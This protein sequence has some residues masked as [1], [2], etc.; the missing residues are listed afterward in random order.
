MGPTCTAI[1]PIIDCE[2]HRMLR[3]YKFITW[4]ISVAQF[5]GEDSK[6][7]TYGFQ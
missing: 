3:F 1:G 6:I 4:D 7:K 5:S 2:D